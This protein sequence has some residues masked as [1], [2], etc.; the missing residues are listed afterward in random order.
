MEEKDKKSRVPRKS[1][2]FY[3]TIRGPTV[4]G[5][6]FDAKSEAVSQ[7]PLHMAAKKGEV[8]SVRSLLLDSEVLS[9]LNEMDEEGA[10]PLHLA[11]EYGS[12]ELV[13]L[14]VQS[15][16]NV[17]QV[18]G[19]GSTPLLR[20]AE[21][22]HKEVVQHLVKDC[23]AEVNHAHSIGWTAVHMAASKGHVEV[24]RFLVGECGAEVNQLGRT[25]GST[26][27]L[28]AADHGYTDVVRCLV[29]ECGASMDLQ[30]F[31]GRTP[32]HAALGRGDRA[33]VRVLMVDG[34]RDHPADLFL[35]DA[36]GR[37]PLH[38]A[39]SSGHMLV[40][41][42]AIA[43]II[44]M[45]LLE[46]LPRVLYGLIAHYATPWPDGVEEDDDEWWE[47]GEGEE[48]KDGRVG[49]GTLLQLQKYLRDGGGEEGDKDP[50]IVLPAGGLH[51]RPHGESV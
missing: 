39:H 35:H 19:F 47:E 41:S 46:L 21:N 38:V 2:E 5:A 24:L 31:A 11:A 10:T 43:D 28:V 12:L 22:G 25:C 17:H 33:T 16:A 42:D 45:S 49:V 27:L 18:D 29:S 51:T 7:S 3:I 50:H 36:Q 44:Q 34:W 32:L 1:S 23:G 6:G 48:V 8:D 13:R 20:A 14:L 40:I 37:T 26:P 30:S 9:R 15:K 4:E